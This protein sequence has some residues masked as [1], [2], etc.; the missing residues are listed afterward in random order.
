MTTKIKSKDAQTS[1]ITSLNKDTLVTSR[2]WATTPTISETIQ[3]TLKTRLTSLLLHITRLVARLDQ[4]K[5]TILERSYEYVT[6]LDGSVH[7]K[8]LLYHVR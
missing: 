6:K 7:G 3:E 5:N 8:V 1:L 4:R 2:R